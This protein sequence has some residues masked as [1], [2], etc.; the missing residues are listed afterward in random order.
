MLS[1]DNN[2]AVTVDVAVCRGNAVVKLD[3]SQTALTLSRVCHR[4][5]RRTMGAHGTLVEVCVTKTKKNILKLTPTLSRRQ[6][7]TRKGYGGCLARA[8]CHPQGQIRLCISMQVRCLHTGTKPK[9]WLDQIPVRHGSLTYHFDVV[10]CDRITVSTAGI[11]SGSNAS[12][13]PQSC[14]FIFGT[15]F[16]HKHLISFPLM[17]DI[18]SLLDEKRVLLVTESEG[19]PPPTKERRCPPWAKIEGVLVLWR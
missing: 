11:E 5:T 6:K 7:L 8:I 15:G 2:R 13:I 18:L 9:F 17:E 14:N 16:L 1:D 19:C 10:E 3:W 4:I 12:Q